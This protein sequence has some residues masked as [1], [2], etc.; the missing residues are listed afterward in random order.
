ME[1]QTDLRWRGYVLSEASK[2]LSRMLPAKRLRWA[3]MMFL[4]LCFAQLQTNRVTVKKHLVY[5]S[6]VPVPRPEIFNTPCHKLVWVSG[7]WCALA[8]RWQTVL[9]AVVRGDPWV[10]VD[11]VLGAWCW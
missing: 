11:Q 6:E 2:L 10:T 1:S 3:V 8:D 9:V 7:E 4:G 5:N